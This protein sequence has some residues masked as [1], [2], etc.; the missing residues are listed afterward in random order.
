MTKDD[1]FTVVLVSLENLLV[2][3][4]R[5]LQKLIDIT[6]SERDLLQRGDTALLM[7]VVEEKEAM[8]DKLSLLED[9]RRMLIQ[10]ISLKLG[11]QSEYTSITDILPWLD[12]PIAQRLT[13]LI[14]GI[15]GL[16]DKA[17]DL[18]IGNQA[19]VYS[20]LDWLKAT[21][22]FLLSFAQSGESYRSPKAVSPSRD[23]R[24]WGLEYRA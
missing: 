15:T 16:V 24:G 20:R 5:S 11:V 8:L 18:N 22:S 19:L 17:R 10:D 13:T 7:K 9:T 6:R 2:K 3:Q 4:F 23:G 21:Q 12:K 14:D 1:N